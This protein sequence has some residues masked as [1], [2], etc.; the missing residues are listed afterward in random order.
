MSR[1]AEESFGSLFFIW[2]IIFCFATWGIWSH[3]R[4][5]TGPTTL[6]TVVS[7]YKKWHKGSYDH[8]LNIQF[9]HDGLK[10]ATSKL[11]IEESHYADFEPGDTFPIKYAKSTPEDTALV[12][13]PFYTTFGGVGYGIM[14]L[15]LVVSFFGML[16]EN[17]PSRP[18][19]RYSKPAKSVRYSAATTLTW[20]ALGAVVF[21]G[22]IVSCRQNA[23][24]TSAPPQ[25]YEYSYAT[26]LRVQYS[27]TTRYTSA[28]VRMP[29]PANQAPVRLSLSPEQHALLRAR[30]S[31]PHAADM[32]VPVAYLPA[33][34]Y[35]VLLA[36]TTLPT[37]QVTDENTPLGISY[38]TL[39]TLLSIIGVVLM[40]RNL[41]KYAR[42]KDD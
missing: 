25:S 5:I 11:A 35:Q 19:E 20:A 3:Y 9:V 23:A 14:V 28:L 13:E 4:T 6:A 15:I 31:R 22:G 27:P 38:N 7:K 41:V 29:A 42:H 30:L 12:G 21:S 18:P 16:R 17:R 34:P 40:M 33:T 8:Y 10:V 39:G 1:N 2:S 36:D 24:A 26:L 32:Q 37:L